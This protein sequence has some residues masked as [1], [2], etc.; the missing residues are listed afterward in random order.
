MDNMNL[1]EIISFDDDLILVEE[2]ENIISSTE[3]VTPNAADSS[4]EK[5]S[6]EEIIETPPVT[7][8]DK[9]DLTPEAEQANSI[10]ELLKESVLDLPE[11]FVFDNTKDGIEKA[12]DLTF[13]NLKQKAQS[14]LLQS[15][16]EEDRLALRF[17]LQGNG[18]IKDFYNEFSPTQGWAD[19]DLED[20]VSQEYV[21]SQYLK[22]T[23][24]YPEAK[25]N[26]LVSQL[27]EN[28]VLEKEAKENIL[29]LIVLEEEQLKKADEALTVREEKLRQDKEQERK[30]ISQL[31]ESL[32]IEGERKSK[33]KGFINNEMNV[34]KGYPST[35][36]FLYTLRQIG[37]NKEHLVQL[38]DI[39]MD[40]TA[41]KGLSLDRITNKATSDSTS[42]IKEKLDSISFSPGNNNTIKP[43][44]NNQF[45]W[46]KWA[47]QF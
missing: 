29:E 4:I 37:Q 22:Q 44:T 7:T 18:S 1:E 25:I 33:L 23:T 17:A 14:S 8:E 42:K 41:E 15:L 34:R 6:V 11:D 20:E 2:E 46:D 27:K 31:V 12:I 45:D 30:E 36:H 28:G 38:A 43:K 21:V 32:S 39:L 26:L 16:S 9:K 35:S 47:K 13:D 5:P 40:Y 19:V 24:R 3:E 10:F